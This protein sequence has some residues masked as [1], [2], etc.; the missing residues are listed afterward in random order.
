MQLTSKDVPS[1]KLCGT[2][3]VTS[4]SVGPQTLFLASDSEI[5]ETTDDTFNTE[6]I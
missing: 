1:L 6:E 3:C 2:V 4:K 5:L